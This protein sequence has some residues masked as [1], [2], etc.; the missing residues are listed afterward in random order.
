MS[1]SERTPDSFLSH[2]EATILHQVCAEVGVSAELVAAAIEEE[3]KVYGMG[4][5]HGIF[6]R[7]DELFRRHC[8]ETKGE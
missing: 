7:L 1:E 4:R 3:H 2:E 8:G 5:R 6:E